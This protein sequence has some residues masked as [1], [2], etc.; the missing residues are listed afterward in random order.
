MYKLVNTTLLPQELNK[1]PVFK[2]L[3]N[4]YPGFTNFDRMIKVYTDN[5]FYSKFNAAVSSGRPSYINKFDYKASHFLLT[6][7][8]QEYKVQKCALV[9]RGTTETFKI[10]DPRSEMRFGRFASTSRN[11]KAAF[12]FGKTSCFKVKTCFGADISKLSVYSFEEEVLVPPFEKFQI[13]K[14]E[15][16]VMGCGTLYT[17][18]STGKLSYMDC[19]LF[20]KATN[21]M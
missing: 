3:W 8:V 7:G 13:K 4:K 15:K 14:M 18:E 2:S 1:N 21:L 5:D 19:E 20:K 12:K 6:R 9:Y 16:N 10:S 17:M 11:I